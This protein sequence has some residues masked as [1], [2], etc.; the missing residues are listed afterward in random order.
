MFRSPLGKSYLVFCH[1][2]IPLVFGYSAWQHFHDRQFLRWEYVVLLA[3]ATLPFLLPVLS[4]YIRGIGKDGISLYDPFQSRASAR[5]VDKLAIEFGP[6][7]N[8]ARVEYR[9]IRRVPAQFDDLTWRAKKVIRTLWKFQ[10]E[11]FG[12]DDPRRWGFGIHP[13]AADYTDFRIGATELL[14]VGFIVEDGRGMIF[15]SSAGIS[16]CKE[17][18]VRNAL[19]AG[20]DIWS[21]FGN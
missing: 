12:E 16:F 2:V 8:G 5:E 14:A 11:Q 3:I 17:P 10:R 1:L 20:G 18:G 9:D 13:T 4:C 6:V 21:K 19:E 7:P 15:L